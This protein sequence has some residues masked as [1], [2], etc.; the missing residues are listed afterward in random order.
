KGDE[1]VS[2]MVLRLIEPDG[3]SIKLEKVALHDS[4]LDI[5]VPQ[6]LGNGTHV[7]SWR[8]VSEDGHPIGGSIVFSIGTP[9]AAPA[10]VTEAI[11][12]PVRAT[13][14]A[15]KIALYAGLFFGVGGASFLA[16]IGP[17]SGR[18]KVLILGSL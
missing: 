2:P 13:V 3:S 14:W 11:D 12:W 7:L 15:W 1:R 4:T 9:S 16:W 8:V 18:A 5:Q 6:G 10:A 17:A